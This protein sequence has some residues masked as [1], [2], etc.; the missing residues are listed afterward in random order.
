MTLP[1]TGFFMKAV[2]LGEAHKQIEA[3]KRAR[4]NEADRRDFNRRRMHSMCPVHCHLFSAVW[5]R[6]LI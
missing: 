4:E 3:D 2:G 6:K 5:D 1:L